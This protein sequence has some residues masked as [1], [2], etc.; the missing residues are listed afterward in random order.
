M[1]MKR[2]DI[3]GQVSLKNIPETKKETPMKNKKSC[4]F[5]F[6]FTFR[7]FFIDIT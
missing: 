3:P 6:V 5:F 4:M 1:S 7:Y 2:A